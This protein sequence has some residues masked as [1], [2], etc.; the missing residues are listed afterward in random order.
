MHCEREQNSVFD[1]KDF[2]STVKTDLRR[3]ISSRASLCV[4]LQLKGDCDAS[5][6]SFSLRLSVCV[7]TSL[8]CIPFLNVVASLPKGA[9]HSYSIVQGKGC[10]RPIFLTIST[11]STGLVAKAMLFATDRTEIKDLRCMVVSSIS[12][13][14]HKPGERELAALR[15]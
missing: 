11:S 2:L 8:L 1:E 12:D 3:L 15:H 4:A 13:T 5:L 10:W 6:K 7:S 9:K 14:L